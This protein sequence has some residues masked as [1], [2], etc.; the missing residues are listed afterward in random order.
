MNFFRVSVAGQEETPEQLGEM[1]I[2][3]LPEL[4][5]GEETPA[6]EDMPIPQ[7]PGFIATLIGNLFGRRED[8][9]AID[10]EEDARVTKLVLYKDRTE[11]EVRFL[12]KVIDSLYP[13]VYKRTRDEFEKSPDFQIY[14]KVRQRY[15]VEEE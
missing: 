8:L 3:Q 14:Q 7:S 4:E 15:V 10:K 5:E 12:L 1:E 6:Q 11:K 2:I 9:P 13:R